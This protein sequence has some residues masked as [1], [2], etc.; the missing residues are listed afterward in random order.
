MGKED[1]RRLVQ[2]GQP[3]LDE[4]VT[5]VSNQKIIYDDAKYQ[6][7]LADTELAR[8]KAQSDSAAEKLA[9][10]KSLFDG[11]EDQRSAFESAVESAKA[12]TLNYEAGER[13]LANT[14]NRDDELGNRLVSQAQALETYARNVIEPVPPADP[15]LA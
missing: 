9:T 14:T 3:K 5:A 13:L 10:A 6:A 12:S 4:L 2:I 1:T 15:P 7:D 8:A 11:L